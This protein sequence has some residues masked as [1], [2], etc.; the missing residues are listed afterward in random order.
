MLY[1]E[2]RSSP[3]DGYEA[4]GRRPLGRTEALQAKTRT[5]NE[6]HYQWDANGRLRQV[7][8]KQKKPFFGLWLTLFLVSLLLL[9]ALVVLV[10][11]TL[12]GITYRYLPTVTFVN[13]SLVA[14]DKPTYQNY[15]TYRKYMD[16]DTIYPGVY[17]DGISLGGMTT[18]EAEAV[19]GAAGETNAQPFNITVNIGNKAWSITSDMLHKSRNVSQMAALAHSYGRTNTTSIR[20]TRMTPYQERLNA[21]LSLR[22]NPIGLY[23]EESYDDGSLRAMTDSIVAYVNREPVNAMVESFSFVD[24]TFTFTTDQPGAKVDGNL[25]FH[26]VKAC[27]D[28]GDNFATLTIVPERVLAR[29]TKAELMNSFGKISTYTTDTTSNDNRN[30]NIDLS[31]RAINGITVLPGETFSFN[32]TTGERTAEKGYKPAAAIAGGQSR[33]E[34]G[35][36]VCQTS[37]TLFNAVA[38]AGLEI[39]KRSPHAWPSNYVEKGMDATVNWPDLDFRFKNNTDWPIFIVAKYH[40]RKVTVDIYGRML[41]DGMTIDLE[42]EVTRTIEPPDGVKFVQNSALTPGTSETTVKRRTG[43]AVDTYQLWYQNGE[44]VKREKLCSSTYK[45]YQETVEYN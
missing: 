21:A 12:T 43:Y 19:L 5:E 7:N 28:S 41:P 29:V 16:T 35:G 11:P 31:A 24:Q 10:L 27:L 3:Y 22:S 39:V 20:G 38:R 15:L 36:G 1:P 9:A 14:M 25:L 30:T 2:Q 42:S 8:G 26:Q 45:A 32:R 44:V 37:S 34:I 13:G 17:V 18:A 40:K 4:P 33:D 23:S 6:P